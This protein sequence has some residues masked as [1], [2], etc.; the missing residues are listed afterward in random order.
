MRNLKRLA[1]LT[2]S[3]ALALSI[4]VPAFA[5]V[6]DTG[7][8]DVGAD[9]WYAE[10]AV[11]CRDNGLMSGTSA[12]TFS[13]DTPMTRAML[14]AVLYRLEGSPAVTGADSFT[15]TTDGAWYADAVLWASQNGIVSG[16][17][18]G[19]FGT[20]DPI[21]REQLATIL[22]RYSDS[23]S[24][25]AGNSFAD[26]SAISSWADTAVDW[27]RSN[28]YINGME[29]NRF[30]P[31]GQATRAQVA[32]ILMRYDSDTQM[33]T[34]PTPEPSEDTR[35]LIAYFSRWGNT[36]Y[37]N[38]V[39]ASTSASIVVNEGEQMGTTELIARMIQDEVGGNLHLIQTA[40]PYSTDF[41][42]VTNENH[43]EQN[44]GTRPELS[45]SIDVSDYDV[46]FIGYPVWATTTPTPVLSFLERADL[47]GKT[48]I[49]FC[50]HDGYGA[51]SSYSAV[52]QASPGAAVE[53]GIA[54]EASDV[55]GA[56][57]RVASWLSGLDLPGADTEHVQG[58]TVIRITI[59]GMELEGVLYD[60]N[61]AR[62]FISQL[63]QTISMSNYGGREVYGSID[64]EITVEGDGQLRFEDGDITYCPAN[65]TAAIFYAQSVR[66]NL[67]MEVYPIGKVTSDLSIFP[68]LPSRVD[69]TFE[70]AE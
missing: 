66:P 30:A 49:P 22:W 15:D 68:D 32:A 35:I 39:D 53:E 48:V 41:D 46:I 2:M 13:P 61:M 34:E 24:A 40:D 56:Q 64:R 70:V 19:L 7:F 12:T 11:Y 59:D 55:S 37:D 18:G 58:E 69:I 26:E 57:S 43:Q 25:D 23:P 6:D 20:N 42:Q 29:G 8:S 9:S 33:P 14:A 31:K 3:A 52:A 50:T 38:D 62:Q 4:S 17:G 45:S 5:A 16:Y 67:T 63:P 1:S 47:T 65:N 21:T 44:A 10:A 60:S 36:D 54:I 27:A 51:G 28:G